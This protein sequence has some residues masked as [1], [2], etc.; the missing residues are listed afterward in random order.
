MRDQNRDNRE[1]TPGCFFFRLSVEC[2]GH[3]PFLPGAQL[4]GSD[5]NGNRTHLRKR[6]F[7]G[8]APRQ[9]WNEAFAI[10]KTVYLLSLAEA[11]E[12]PEP[13]LDHGCCS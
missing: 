4:A 10:E 12:L 6:I 7:Q 8:V 1:S 3:F 11:A 13:S 5:E 9:P 2:E